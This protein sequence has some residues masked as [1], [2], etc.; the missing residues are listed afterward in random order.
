MDGVLLVLGSG[1]RR[2]REHL[3][4]SAARRLPI[5]LF[6]REKPTWQTPYLHGHDVVDLTDPSAVVAAARRLANRTPVLGVL[7]YQEQVITAAAEVTA[8]L[9][10]PGMNPA[11]VHSCRDKGRTRTLLAEARVAQPR[12]AMVL[13]PADALSAG[14]RIG[15]PLVVKPRGGGGSHGVVQAYDQAELIWATEVALASGV[16]GLADDYR[17]IL[18][19]EYL[20]GEEISV[21]CAIFD[22][23]CTPFVLARKELGPAPYFEEIGHGVSATDPLLTDP[24]LHTLLTR[25]HTALGVTHG[26]THTEIRFGPHGPAVI[27]V[28]GRLGGGLIPYLGWLASGI[29]A[30]DVAVDLALGRRS[31]LTATGTASAAIR[32]YPP[33]E[34]CR[35]VSLRLPSAA[36]VPEI[37]ESCPLA[38]PGDELRVPPNGFGSRLGYTIVR[39]DTPQ[40]C[41][42]ALAR[43]QKEVAIDAEPLSQL[44]AN[45]NM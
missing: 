33:T 27:E 35:L 1:V 36:T 6:D 32:F 43:A 19:E 17:G 20:A 42:E 4:V 3:L 24:A 5:H 44:S 22:G 30:A 45:G 38:A 15:Y 41:A 31:R 26:I 21:D 23:E 34:D 9:G 13:S 8:A 18:V 2:F 12:F 16:P 25:T 28:N 10:L 39:A 11:A 29:D 14:E 37:V 40:A 7:C